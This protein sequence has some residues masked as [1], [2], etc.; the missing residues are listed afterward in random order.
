MPGL[1][2]ALAAIYLGAFGPRFWWRGVA[3]LGVVM[4]AAGVVATFQAA[5]DAH[6]AGFRFAITPASIAMGLGGQMLFTMAFYGMALLCWWSYRGLTKPAAE[7][8]VGE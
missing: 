5:D 8:S 1:L 7:R 3:V 2:V 6:A 4:I